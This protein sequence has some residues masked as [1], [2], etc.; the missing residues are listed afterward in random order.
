MTV[1]GRSMPPDPVRCPTHLALPPLEMWGGAEC[2]I[3]RVGNRVRDQFELGGQYG[4]PDDAERI[5]DLGVRAVRWPI[6]WERHDADDEAWRHTDRALETFRRR[7][8]RVI[9]G[10]LHHG[11]GPRHTHLLHDGF[12]DG[13]AGFAG[14]VAER[15]PWIRDYTPVNEPLTTARFSTLYGLWYPHQRSNDAF[16]RALLAQVR[17]MQR[18][19]AAILPFSPDARL[20]ATEDLGFTHTTP[21]LAEQG[22][23]DNERRWLT[24]DLLT[25]R[26]DRNHALWRWLCRCAPARGT[27]D[28]IS[29]AAIDVRLRPAILGMNY[30]VTSERFL[31][32]DIGRYPSQFRGGN[33][34]QSYAD[35]EAVRVL[36]GDLLGHEALIEQASDRYALPI[37]VTE[38]HLSC[39]R[40][41]QML[42]LQ[43]A[44]SA[45]CRL[46]ERGHDVRAITTWA[47]YGAF[48]WSSLLVKDASDY[49]CGAYDLRSPAPRPTALVPMIQALAS[50]G[51]YE[52]PVLQGEPWWSGPRRLAYAPRDGA[53]AL[54]GVDGPRRRVIPTPRRRSSAQPL[55]ITGASGTL[56]HA[57][58]RVARDRGLATVALSRRQLDVTD[59]AATDRWLQS[60][61]PWAVINAA[62]WVQ[63]DAAEGMH[64]ECMRLNADAAA[65]LAEA[66]YKR[67]IAFV[68]FSSDLVFGG[69]IARP[70]VESDRVAPQNCYGR[71]K[72]AAERAVAAIDPDALVIRSSAFFG[73][74]DDWNFVS[75]TLA[76]VSA[77]RN[78]AV[79]DDCEVSPTYLPDLAHATYDL[80]IDGARGIWHVANVGGCTWLDL[81]RSATTH[82]GLDASRVVPCSSAAFGWHAPRPRYSVLASERATLLGDLDDA[83]M[84]YC[85]A[86]PWQRVALIGRSQAKNA[87]PP[88]PSR[89]RGHVPTS[90]S[91]A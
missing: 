24:W 15:Y 51:H 74:W 40:E 56:G 33:G 84:R 39:S 48:D 16:V 37:A 20:I 18:A 14:R 73:D 42:W 46:R 55:V 19:M 66:C 28:E 72:V 77:G 3:N 21:L 45:A 44:W 25:G 58:Q 32:D 54:H 36:R 29:N 78:V 52:H 50:H 6:L 26:V 30:Y 86:K 2:T 59:A 43:Q 68:T 61:A 57:L 64:A 87:A 82:A 88:S 79:P 5:A 35:V 63:V 76:D 71:S 41:Q 70:L 34:K 47:L 23:F 53:R 81:A 11:S 60:T 7:G 90:R 85:R 27:L 12:V 10:L 38:V 22:A 80:L 65:I 62:G 13:L 17:A 83:L 8:I 67:G 4:R 69:D 1:R 49:E 75:R 31:D 9:A 91:I 89:P